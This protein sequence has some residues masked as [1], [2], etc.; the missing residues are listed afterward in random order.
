MLQIF[1]SHDLQNDHLRWVLLSLFY[2]QGIQGLEKL[3]NFPKFTKTKNLNHCPSDSRAHVP[4][5][6]FQHLSSL[7]G[8]EF[9]FEPKFVCSTHSEAK[10]TATLKFGAEKGLLQ[11]HARR[12]GEG[13]CS[14]P[15]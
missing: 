2:R 7:F 10:Q 4:P 12:M 14:K 1:L 3:S 11:G 15:P 8:G 13:A 5:C 6:C 9:V